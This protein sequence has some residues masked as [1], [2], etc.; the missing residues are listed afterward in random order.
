MCVS[1]GLAGHD[2][3]FGKLD[4]DIAKDVQESEDVDDDEWGD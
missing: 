4:G 3:A 2:Q 1:K